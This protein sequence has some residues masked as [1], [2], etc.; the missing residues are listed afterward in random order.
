M[1]F[2][3]TNQKTGNS[4]SAEETET[5]LDAAMRQSRVF[6]YS[7]RSGACGSCKARLISGEVN[8][9]E[10]TTGVLSKSEKAAGNILLCQAQALSDIVIE[11]NELPPGTAMTIRTLPCRVVSLEKVSHDVMLLQL[12]LPKNQR[13]EYLPGQYID[14][15]LRDGRRRSFSM[16]N[17]PNSEEGLQLHVRLVPDGH[18][19]GQVFTTLKVRDLLRFQGPLGTFFLR[20]D[21]TWPVIMVGGGTG[22]APLKAIL[23]NA[24][25]KHP[26]RAFH[27]FWGVRS[28]EDLYLDNEIR[29]WLDVHPNL[30]YTPVLSEP[31]I[32][33]RWD[34]EIGLVHEAVLRKYPELDGFEVYASGPPPMIEALKAAFAAHGLP[35]ER[36]FFD[37]F[38]FTADSC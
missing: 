15:L 24:L 4:F 38:E 22:L 21:E 25:V 7:C 23:D 31:K 33:D 10:Y 30:S 27:L 14:I 28:A 37:S 35:P 8:P 34:G 1:T 26:A 32:A 12:K 13:F 6:S 9:G 2:Q 17:A 5:V 19:T 16:A 20:E 29:R 36:L 18:F 11:A 3:V